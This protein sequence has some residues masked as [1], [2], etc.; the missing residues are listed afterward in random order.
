MPHG[1]ERQANNMKASCDDCNDDCV[2]V[3]AGHSEIRISVEAGIVTLVVFTRDDAFQEVPVHTSL[4]LEE[5]RILGSYLLEA[6]KDAEVRA[7]QE[8]R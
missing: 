5:A 7:G 3:L 4:V 8:P 2:V 6:A 1:A